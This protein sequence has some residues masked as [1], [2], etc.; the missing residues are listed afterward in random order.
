MLSGGNRKTRVNSQLIAD[1]KRMMS[2]PAEMAKIKQFIGNNDPQQMFY[3]ACNQYGIDPEDIL[4][5]LR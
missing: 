3:A 5:E 1:A 2:M 4:S